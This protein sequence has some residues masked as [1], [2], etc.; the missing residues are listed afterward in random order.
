MKV[1][2]AL[3]S[4]LF[5][6]SAFAQ[7]IVINEIAWMG[8]PIQGVEEKQWWR[9]EWLELYN[10]A[11]TAGMLDGWNVELYRGNELY[12][13]IPLVGTVLPMGYFLVGASDKILGVDVNYSNLGGKFLNTGQKVVLSN[14]TDAVV[15][16]VDATAGWPGGDNKTKQTMEKTSQGWQTSKDSGGTPKVP[17]SEG[18][19]KLSLVKDSLT[20]L[21]FTQ[22]ETEKDPI[23][24][25]SLSSPQLQ[26]FESRV[27]IVNPITL[28]AGFLALGFSGVLL[29][30]RRS[31]ASRQARLRSRQERRQS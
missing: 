25:S 3:V 7:S 19:P 31:F 23:R 8:T 30:V 18:V 10:N 16:E 26:Q 2:L 9:Y 27:P 12:F 24:S 14:A 20:K 21:S 4:L 15:D 22:E 11:D 6:L 5:P 17:N 29:L 13:T 1:F 28:L